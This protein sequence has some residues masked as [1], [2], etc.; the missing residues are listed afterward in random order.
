MSSSTPAPAVA[1]IGSANMDLV[2]RA[3]RVPAPGETILGH[4]FATMPGGK[5]ANQAVAAA[6]L[7]A[8]CRFV[9]RVGDDDFGQRLLASLTAA[10][11]NCQHVTVTE[12]LATGVALIV[13]DE[14]GENAI[15]VAR[16]ANGK[17]SPEDIDAA[18]PIIA[19]ARVCLLQL[20]IPLQTV[21]HAIR[22]AKRHNVEVIVDCAPAPAPEKVPPALFQADILTPNQSEAQILTGEPAAG[23]REARLVAAALAERGAKQVVLKLGERGAL[24]FD[25]NHFEHVRGYRIKPVDTTAAGDAF[26][27]ALAVCRA[28]GMNLFDSAK[29]ANAAGAAACLKFGAQPAMPTAEEVVM[30]MYEDAD[31]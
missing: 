5:G 11:V 15:C 29:Y 21:S 16:G 14:L 13:V 28:K 30:V 22:L 3:A 12:G 23:K 4:D 31:Q 18:E 25:G 26:T 27:A 19:S 9:A 8:D 2:V 24:A 6:R 20:E 7:G 17:L 10:G 1:V